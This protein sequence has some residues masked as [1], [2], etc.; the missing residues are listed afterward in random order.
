V[1]QREGLATPEEMIRHVSAQLAVEFSDSFSTETIEGVT[2]EYLD[3][4]R[5]APVQA[6][7]P[8]LVHRRAKEHLRK[9]ANRDQ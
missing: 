6:F 2:S 1:S 5:D 9:L 7:V 3:P 8:L 4:L